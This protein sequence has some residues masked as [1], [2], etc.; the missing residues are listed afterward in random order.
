MAKIGHLTALE[1]TFGALHEQLVL[2]ECVKD[3]L[4]VVKMLRP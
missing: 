3:K 2:M 4:Q 1:C